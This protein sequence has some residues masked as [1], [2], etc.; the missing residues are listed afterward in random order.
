MKKGKF[1][2]I[3]YSWGLNYIIYYN[4]N[5]KSKPEKIDFGKIIDISK[6]VSPDFGTSNEYRI[7]CICY[8]NETKN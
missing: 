1:G 2:Y 7:N 4:Y 5:S 6:F 8:K 3:S